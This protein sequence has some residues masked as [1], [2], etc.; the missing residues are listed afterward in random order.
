MVRRAERR[1]RLPAALKQTRHRV[2]HRNLG[3]SDESGNSPGNAA[4]ALICCP[5]ADK[6]DVVR[7]ARG[8]FER[9]L[10]LPTDIAKIWH[11]AIADDRRAQ[12][13]SA[14]PR[15]ERLISESKVGSDHFTACPGGL[16][17]GFWADEGRALRVC[18][19]RRCAPALAP[20]PSSP[21]SPAH[22]VIQR[23]AWRRSP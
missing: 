6:E 13:A 4:R 10:G 1:V 2:Q 21:S 7:T 20:A 22:D 9:S 11:G 14:P 18:G 16:R 8:D 17:P 15:H 5:A 19:H 12:A 3:N 23:I